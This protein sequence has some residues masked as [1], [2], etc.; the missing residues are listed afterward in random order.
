MAATS[1]LND[2]KTMLGV[3]LSDY[4]FDSDIITHINMSL[5]IIN[6]L[7][8]G[9]SDGLVVADYTTLWSALLSSG[10][11]LSLIKTYVYLKVRLVFDP[12]TTSYLIEAKERQFKELEYRISI[13][14][15]QTSWVAPTPRVI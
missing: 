4:N 8:V 3:N 13:N 14:R 1:I 10:P 6:Q 9:P 15:E 2:V 5:G 11:T 7:G 12:P